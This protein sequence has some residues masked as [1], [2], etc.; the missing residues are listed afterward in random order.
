MRTWA[1]GDPGDPAAVVIANCHHSPRRRRPRHAWHRHLPS[2]LERRQRRPGGPGSL[3]VR[4]PPHLGGGAGGDVGHHGDRPLVGMVRS[5]AVA[6][7]RRLPLHP[8]RVRGAGGHDLGHGHARRHPRGGAAVQHQ[9][10]DLLQARCD[11]I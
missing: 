6:A 4:R 10:P 8:G 2:T 1:A 9:V 11:G 5:P 3:P 7:L